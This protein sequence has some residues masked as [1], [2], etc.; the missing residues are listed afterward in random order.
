MHLQEIWSQ[1]FEWHLYYVSN[2][3]NVYEKVLPEPYRPMIRSVSCLWTSS[4]RWNSAKY[5]QCHWLE[6]AGEEMGLKT[7][8]I[9]WNKTIVQK[10][11]KILSQKIYVFLW[12]WLLILGVVTFISLIYN[13]FLFATPQLRWDLFFTWIFL[14]N[15]S[16]QTICLD[17]FDQQTN[18]SQLT[19]GA[20]AE[21][22]CWRA[23]QLTK[24]RPPRR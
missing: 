5:S 15:K 6:K 7:K 2:F 23:A 10:I 22:G 18:K 4:M 19:N 8:N 9:I 14:T 24:S 12:F 13:C 20:C 17:I 21:I 11:C 16:L 3:Q 1:P